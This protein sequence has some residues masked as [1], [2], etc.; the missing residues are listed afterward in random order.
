VANHITLNNV[1]YQRHNQQRAYIV[2]NPIWLATEAAKSTKKSYAQDFL[3]PEQQQ[4][5]ILQIHLDKKMEAPP[6]P[7]KT[8]GRPKMTYTQ[9]T[10]NTIETPTITEN[11]PQEHILIKIMQESFTRFKTIL[12]KQA[13]QMST[14]MNL[15]TTVLNKLVK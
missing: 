8:E 6:A 3:L 1:L 14:L 15:L 7:Q 13:E 12:S 9:A 4:V 11:K 2:G 10:R 5:F